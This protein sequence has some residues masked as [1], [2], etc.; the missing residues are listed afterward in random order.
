MGI[1]ARAR[2]RFRSRRNRPEDVSDE[3]LTNGVRFIG[4]QGPDGQ[5]QE[6]D[7]S[8][9]SADAYFS[10]SW[11]GCLLAKARPLASLPVHVYVRR[12]GIREDATGRFPKRYMQLL[13]HRWNPVMTASEGTRWLMMTKDTKGEAF[14]R[15]EYDANGMPTSIWPLSG[16]PTIEV[17]DGKF[18]FRYGGD[19][20]T[21]PGVYLG[22]EIIWIKSPIL[23]SECLHGVSLAKLAAR[24]LGLS[25]DLDEFYEAAIHGNAT[26]AGWLEAPGRLNPQDI[27]LLQQQLNDGSGVVS[28]GKVRIFSNGVTYKSNGQS[29]VEMNVVEQEKWI[30][31]Q[32]C[33]TL[34]VPPQE[35]FDLSNATYSNIEQGALDF[36]NKTLVPECVALEQ[37]YSSPLWAA[38][39]PD[40]Y[41]QMDMNGLLRGSYK[42][43][44][45]GYRIGINAGIYSPNQVRAKEDE[46]PYE[47]GDVYFRSS[48]YIPVDPDTGEELVDR[49]ST[50][51]QQGSFPGSQGEGSDT[52]DPDAMAEGTALAVIH[53]D[54]EDRIR[55]RLEES[56][57]AE[58]TRAF[59]RKVL[60]P[61]D[62]ACRAQGIKYDLNSDMERIING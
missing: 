54:M 6:I 3:A 2:D 59:A 22:N 14:A 23:D 20:F 40:C 24:E 8:S 11:R 1:I 37:A 50:N 43:R 25:I 55:Q 18:V 45:D 48:A 10:N 49:H 15:V 5:Y 16:T 42:E 44:M 53:R 60:G 61:M 4:Y 12:G 7:I 29:M 52:P 33:R 47:G 39:Y 57:D 41:V 36:A 46:E 56:G 28:A 21:K 51:T 9:D 35:V 62:E 32:C 27:D 13:Q 58:K 26:F 30:L 31:Q 34:S 38:G 19:T 17:T